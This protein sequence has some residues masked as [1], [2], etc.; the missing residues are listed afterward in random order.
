MPHPEGRNLQR[1]PADPLAGSH[2]PPSSVASPTVAEKSPGAAAQIDGGQRIDLVG[3]KKDDL[4]NVW[5]DLGMPSAM[6]TPSDIDLQELRGN[7]LTVALGSA[8]ASAWPSRSRAIPGDRRAGQVKLAT[9]GAR[10]TAPKRWSKTSGRWP[11]K[12]PLEIYV[13][14]SR[15]AHPQ[16]TCSRSSITHD[17]V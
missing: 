6:R 2:R 7:R 11:S 9:A 12:G 8:T 17:D 14:G 4:P 1:H 10:A 16:E 3:I 15:R 5:R 13:E